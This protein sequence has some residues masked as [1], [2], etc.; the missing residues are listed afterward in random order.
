[1]KQS[2]FDDWIRSLSLERWSR[3]QHNISPEDFLDRL[4]QGETCLLLDIR[5]SEEQN[6]LTFPQSLTIPLNDLP[7]RWQEIPDDQLVAILCGSGQRA[8]VAYTYLQTMGLS[9]VRI[10]KGGVAMLVQQLSPGRIN[11]LLAQNR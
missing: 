1:M 4:Q 6:Y 10:L 8:T 2:N 7:N 3:G 11:A 9:H 5:F